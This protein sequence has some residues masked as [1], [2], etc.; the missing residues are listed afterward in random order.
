MWRES[1]REKEREREH[2]QG[3]EKK[4]EKINTEKVKERRGMRERKGGS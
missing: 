3:R 2:K 1:D 4:R